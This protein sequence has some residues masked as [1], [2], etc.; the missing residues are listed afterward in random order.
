MMFYEGIVHL[1]KK[2]PV[3]LNDDLKTSLNEIRITM[4]KNT[5]LTYNGDNHVY[6]IYR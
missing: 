3:E 1:N 5:M 2:I 4:G 6:I